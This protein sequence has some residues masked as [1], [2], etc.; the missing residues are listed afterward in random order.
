MMLKG[1][2]TGEKFDKN[3]HPAPQIHQ[4]S[5]D[6]LPVT[7]GITKAVAMPNSCIFSGANGDLR[8][9]SFRGN[10]T[11]FNAEF[12]TSFSPIPISEIRELLVGANTE[13]PYDG[14][15]TLWEQTVA[16]VRGAFRVLTKVEDLTIVSCE[17]EPFFT[18]LGAATD[19]PIL[20]PGLRR[21]TIYVG[22]GGPDVSAL[23]RCAEARFESSGPLGELTVIFENEPKAYMV[24]EVELLRGFVEELSY[25]VGASPGMKI[26]ESRDGDTW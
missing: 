7:R 9:W 4:S 26:W 6:H 14:F 8:F 16:R 12:F 3:G 5:I 2:F 13:F 1:Q 23:I 22:S 20:L 11:N 18:A 24:Q 15:P 17:T 10:R 21:L 25:R 19:G